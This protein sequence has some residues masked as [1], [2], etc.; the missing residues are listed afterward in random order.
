MEFSLTDEEKS[1][2]CAFY[3]YAMK[4]KDLGLVEDC[5]IDSFNVIIHNAIHSNLVCSRRYFQSQLEQYDFKLLNCLPQQ[6][7]LF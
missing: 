6:R 4:C 2:V 3:E 7:R 1:Q 5:E